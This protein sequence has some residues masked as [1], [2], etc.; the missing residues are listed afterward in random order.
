M[1]RINIITAVLISKYTEISIKY[2]P[3]SVEHN[4][5]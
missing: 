3:H 4:G 2:G 1:I 5:T